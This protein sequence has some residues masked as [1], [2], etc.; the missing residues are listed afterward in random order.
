MDMGAQ[1]VAL[2]PVGANSPGVYSG[3]GDMT[4][5]GHWGV[6]VKV[7]PPGAPQPL[8]PSFKLTIGISEAEMREGASVF[9]SPSARLNDVYC[10]CRRCVA[11]PPGAAQ[12]RVRCLLLIRRIAPEIAIAVRRRRSALD[13]CAWSVFPTPSCWTTT[14]DEEL[15]GGLRNQRSGT[16]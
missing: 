13:G 14:R 4:M 2:K 5:G 1:D 12:P 7:V 3:A 8:T 16:L 9:T 11:R 15:I 10:I 6:V